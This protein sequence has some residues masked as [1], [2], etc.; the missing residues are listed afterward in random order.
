MSNRFE[1]DRRRLGCGRSALR[2]VPVLCVCLAAALVAGCGG[3][4][5]SSGPDAVDTVAPAT[6]PTR[7]VATRA[8]EKRDTIV[9]HGEDE[10][11]PFRLVDDDMLPF[12]TYVPKGIIQGERISTSQESGVQFFSNSNN[13]LDTATYMKILLPSAGT[14]L[15]ALHRRI[16]GDSTALMPANG[17]EPREDG[18]AARRECPWAVE[19]HFHSTFV[20]GEKYEGYVCVGRHDSIPFYVVTHYPAS[21]GSDFLPRVRAILDNLRWDDTGNGLNGKPVVDD[22]PPDESDSTDF[23]AGL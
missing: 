22:V 16:V 19:S 15:K 18:A 10:V 21:A 20:D 6:H 23:D 9:L 1:T 8:A 14:T 17:W 2:K 13:T 11:V 12:S 5:S 4:P 3:T 7:A